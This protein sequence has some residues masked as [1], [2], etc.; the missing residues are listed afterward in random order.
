LSLEPIIHRILNIYHTDASRQDLKIRV[1]WQY[2]VY[3]SAR[4]CDRIFYEKAVLTLM[5][6][7]STAALVLLVVFSW[8]NLRGI[9]PALT[10]PSRDIVPLIENAQADDGA[11]G[12]PPKLARVSP[13][14][15][16]KGLGNRVMALDPA[17][18]LLVSIPSH[19]KVV[20]LPDQDRDGSPTTQS[21]W[22]MD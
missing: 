4:C 20:A 10:A 22:S 18:T 1:N 3:T 6:L 19:G 5:L 14:L 17:G 2:A 21:R 11:G 16:A 7:C 12:M 15:F 9:G 8:K 13:S